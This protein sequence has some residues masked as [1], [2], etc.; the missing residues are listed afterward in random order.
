MILATRHSPGTGKMME[1]RKN[2]GHHLRIIT[3][4]ISLTV[5]TCRYCPQIQ[6]R[7]GGEERCACAQ[8]RHTEPRVA[9]YS[10]PSILHLF[11]L[12]NCILLFYTLSRELLDDLTSKWTY[13]KLSSWA[14]QPLVQLGQCAKE[15]DY[16]KPVTLRFLDA[17]ASP[18]SYPCQ[19]VS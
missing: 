1:R 6:V 5:R 8:S 17:I 13:C 7:F 4:Y 19:W 12:V 14:L 2:N 3:H 16:W 10:G 15:Y 18:S 11:T 9:H